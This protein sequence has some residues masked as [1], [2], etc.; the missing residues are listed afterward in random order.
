MER[1]GDRGPAWLGIGAQRSGTSWFTDLLIQHPQVELSLCG[2]KEMHFLNRALVEPWDDE[3]RASYVAQFATDGLAGEFTPAYLRSLWVP[4]VAATVIGRDVPIIVLLRDPIDRYTS[5]I[6]KGLYH[7][8]PG[9]GARHKKAKRFA[10]TA[11]LDAQWA[12]MYASQLAAWLRVFPREQLHV[13][14][15]ERVTRDPQSAV[16]EIWEALGLSSIT[17]TDPSSREG[18]IDTSAVTWSVDLVPGL[19]DQLRALYAPEV[20]EMEREWGFDP[21][22]WRNFD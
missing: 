22:L 19:R 6:R 7:Q 4:A 2:S 14:Q 21:G 1:R 5:A 8:T 16:N 12:G 13:L 18:R 3:R 9:V 15:Y 17:L 10:R 20:R 11:G